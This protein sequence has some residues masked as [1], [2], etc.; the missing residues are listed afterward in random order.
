[1]RVQRADFGLAQSLAGAAHQSR[2]EALRPSRR[3]PWAL[4]RMTKFFD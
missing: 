3:A 1:M 4:L 2:I